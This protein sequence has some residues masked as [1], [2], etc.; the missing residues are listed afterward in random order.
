MKLTLFASGDLSSA[1]NI[2]KQFGHKMSVL[3]WFQI[4]CHSDIF[5]LKS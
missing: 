5:V 3:I 4:V 2:C 1:D